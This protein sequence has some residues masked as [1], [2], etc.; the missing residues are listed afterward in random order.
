MFE[1]LTLK[2]YYRKYWL[3]TV[4]GIIALA[5]IDLL[6]MLVPRILKTAVDDLVV[7]RA[8]P[9][10]LM[11]A[12]LLI[13]LIALG[14]AVG[15]FFWRYLLIGSARRIER[16]LR[17]DFYIH[18]T[19]LDVAYFDKTKTGDLM[20]HATNDINAVRMSIGFGLVILTD[21]I[22]MGVASIIMMITIDLKLTLYAL[23]PFPFITLFSTFFGHTIHRL[24]EKVQA[25]FSL[26]TERVR[27][28]LAGIRVVKVFVQ[29][30][31][32]IDRFSEISSD[33][34]MKNMSLIKVWGTFFPIIMSLAA[35]GMV[36]V[37][38][39]GGRYVLVGEISVGSFVAFTSYLQMLVWPMI[40]IGRAINLF[41]RGAAS[42]GRINKIMAERSKIKA[43]EGAQEVVKG[44]IVIRDLALT[45]LGKETPA[46]NAVDLEIMPNQFIGIT[47]PIGSGKSS[48]VHVLLRLYEPQ[49]GSVLIDGRNLKDLAPGFVRSQIS[50]VPQD[51]FLFSDSVRNNV[52]FGN[53][54]ASTADIERVCR[55][56]SIHE[57][58]L[59]LPDGF[60]TRIGERGITLSGGQKQRLALARAL[61]LN[62]PILILDDAFSSVDAET[63]RAIL[64]AI[65]TELHGRTSIVISHRLFA[66]MDADRIFVMKNGSIAE[67]G[68][69]RELVGLRRL[70]HDIYRTQ[71]IE[72]KLETL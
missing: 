43:V 52:A 2:K 10:T 57:E 36:I 19:T 71:Q 15:R 9:R 14:V 18:L 67:S 16:E 30:P 39:L 53:P 5:V 48:I 68:T 20:A 72:M 62:R 41:Q 23:I 22:I 40:A 37:L 58:I 49:S 27:E 59:E 45:Y 35:I 11:F 69:H 6:Q 65:R 46:L 8:T 34:V 63:E 4:F 12:C 29:E 24:F 70:Y 50:F 7:G 47:G 66:I 56:A 54:D 31:F 17:S 1:L 32:E 60:D 28:N 51:T 44:H 25:S 3:A 33:Y 26:L 21:I 38:G 13:M 64:N 55:I 42:Q 61:I